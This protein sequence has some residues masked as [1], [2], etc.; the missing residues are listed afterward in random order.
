MSLHEFA[1][2]VKIL[3]VIAAI[4]IGLLV[5]KR[6]A[7]FTAALLERAAY[8][9]EAR[10]LTWLQDRATSRVLGVDV[11]IVRQRRKMD[12]TNKPISY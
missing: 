6:L 11:E 3:G 4:Y 1:I 12:S 9:L 5:I 8:P 2:G 10:L 7:I